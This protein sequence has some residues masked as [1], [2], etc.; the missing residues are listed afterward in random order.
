MRT[1]LT[2]RLTYG[3]NVAA[4]ILLAA[5]LTVMANWIA[6]KYPRRHD[7]LQ[8]SDLYQLS[9][10]TK[11]VLKML[12]Q[13]VTFYVFSAPQESELYP[14]ISRLL[15]AYQ[16]ASPRVKFEMVDQ[17]RDLDRVRKLAR[18]FIVTEPDT[19]VIKYGDA[20]K[21]LTEMDMGE[22]HF[23][24]NEYTGGQIKEL[25][26]LKAEQAFTSGILELMSPRKILGKFT[27]K[28][29]EKSIFSYEDEGLS[30]VK[31]FL[32][33]DNI[34]PEPLELVGLSEIS[35]SNCDML[36]I[37]GPTRKFLESEIN[38]I[39]RYLNR[40]GRALVMLDPDND[41][42][43][44]PLLAEYNVTLGN[45][46]VIDPERQIPSASP[47][48]LVIGL[49][50]DHPIASRLQTFTIFSIARSVGIKDPNNNVNVA[51]E[52]TATSDKAWGE[53]DTEADR[54]RFDADKDTPGPLCTAVVVDN[55]S[56]GMRLIVVGDSDFAT[57]REE[58]R[59][60]N[61][62]LFLNCV[63]WLVKRETL[64]AIGPKAISEVKRLQLA[65]Y[66][67]NFIA[68]VVLLVVP[69]LSAVIGVFV[70]LSRRK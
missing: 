19:V 28:H 27:V 38:L 25:Q 35:A 32:E 31:R 1:A 53:T 33:R 34:N 45:N 20:K 11:G 6:R 21:L 40:G 46:I 50:H 42:G 8:T 43:L 56:S 44:A 60:A 2:R 41:A 13:D 66:Q 65:P 57:N 15:K 14:K 7:F 47:L 58:S 4:A 17:V 70:Y 54:F 18:E 48:S 3:T 26:Q 22:F 61:R 10:K 37:A 36:V 16:A 64:V 63:N 51:T 67:M 52:L 29:G 39:R 59:G 23:K 9:D 12:T 49:Y 62:D 24:L 5:A 55:Q 68:L 30:E 69:L